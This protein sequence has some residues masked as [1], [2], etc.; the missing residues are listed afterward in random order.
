MNEPKNK[1]LSRRY[2]VA[3]MGRSIVLGI[4]F[5]ESPADHF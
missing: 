4:L 2:I 3:M 5:A 1:E